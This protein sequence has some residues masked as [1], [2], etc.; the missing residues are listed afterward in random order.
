MGEDQIKSTRIVFWFTSRQNNSPGKYLKHSSKTVHNILIIQV[1]IF[2][3]EKTFK[4][5]FRYD[6]ENT[7]KNST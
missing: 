6:K 2:Y 3:V 1:P 7:L 4:N 5:I